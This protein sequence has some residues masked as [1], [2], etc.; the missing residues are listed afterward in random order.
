[1]GIASDMNRINAAKVAIAASIAAKGVTVPG[2]TKIDGMATLIAAITGGDTSDATATA[3]DI[4]DGKT[5]YVNGG[6]I[7]GNIQGM[8][9]LN[10]T[11]GTVPLSV[12]AGVYTLGELTVAAD[13]DCIP[14][15]I[16]AGVQIFSA[17][18]TFT[19]D[20]TAIAADMLSGKTAYVNGALVT[21]SIPSKSAANYT[22]GTT[23]QII[24]AG[25]Y[26]SGAQTILGDADLISANI[27]SGANIFGVAGAA[28][29][30]DT[31]TGDAVAANILSGKKAFVNGALV[32]G[33]IAS[34]G[35]QTYTPGTADQTITSG[36]YLSGNQVISGDADLVSGNIR[37]GVNIFGVAGAAAVV[38][39]SDATAVAA[40]MLSGKTAY[41]NGTKITGTIASKGVATITPGTSNQTI[42]AGQYL[43]G[44]QTILGDTDLIA[45]NI[46]NG[47]DIFGVVG[48]MLGFQASIGSTASPGSAIAVPFSNIRGFMCYWKRTDNTA[49]YG[50]YI[51]AVG[52][53][54]DGSEGFS[55]V[56]GTSLTRGAWTP[57]DVSAG[58]ITPGSLGGTGTCFYAAFG[59]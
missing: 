20:A 44:I 21:G 5:A 3:A 18:G 34:K 4:L 6:K 39:T 55:V 48:T 2:G 53:S 10:Y 43:S 37:S 40:D 54:F 29:V 36:Q 33:S 58:S 1:M 22:P 45:A 27:K 12:P 51:W 17:L 46:K 9:G 23:N 49:R 13:A 30:V 28:A 16:K 14:A 41:V 8:P 47:I 26:L 24:T 59:Y 32:T 52:A 7:T 25:Q 19:N 50:L 35:A 57:I 38:S 42:A 11:P 56:N 31:S 15:N